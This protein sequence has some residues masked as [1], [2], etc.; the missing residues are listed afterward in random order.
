MNPDLLNSTLRQI[1]AVEETYYRTMQEAQETRHTALRQTIELLMRP[2]TAPLN[3]Q[4]DK[5]S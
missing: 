2:P 1:L 5:E 4:P 3:A